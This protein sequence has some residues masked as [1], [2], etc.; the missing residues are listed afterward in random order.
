MAYATY[1]FYSNEYCGTVIPETSFEKF[2]VK[3]SKE[4][5][6]WTYYRLSDTEMTEELEH[7]LQ[8]CACEIAELLYQIDNYN[9]ATSIAENGKGIV[10][11]MSSGSE[12]VSYETNA[13][14]YAKI[15]VDGKERDSSINGIVK[16]WLSVYS[17][18]RGIM[19]CYAGW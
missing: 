12:S 10:K 14:L 9:R 3:A 7:N 11:S 18:N 5:N 2:V 1:E 6:K 4:I 19:L 13:S 15:A 17:D 16:D 8:Y